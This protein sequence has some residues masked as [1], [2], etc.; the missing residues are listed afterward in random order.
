MEDLT[1]DQ[2]DKANKTEGN[3]STP[4]FEEFTVETSTDAPYE[5]Q[6]LDQQDSA[7]SRI[8]L[9]RK[10]RRR[11]IFLKTKQAFLAVTLLLSLAAIGYVLNG[12]GVI[13]FTGTGKDASAVEVKQSQDEEM[14]ECFATAGNTG[15]SLSL[16]AKAG[17]VIAVGFHEAERKEAYAFNPAGNCFNKET[18]TTV[19]GAVLESGNP[20]MFIMNS[21]GR[22]TAATTAADIAMVPNANVY[23]PVDGVVTLVK[24]Y[25]LYSKITDYHIEIQP[26]GFPDLRVVLIHMDDIQIVE[27]QRVKRRE[28]HIGRMRSLPQINSQILRYLPERADHIHMQI[29]PVVDDAGIES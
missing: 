28:T 5:A 25:E 18:T 6:I 17:S 2:G 13:K 1:K 11:Q 3:S 8:K 16:P 27:G 4:S 24:T 9:K 7:E 20:V 21:R 29:N 15:L 22:G 12:I 26:D 10:L 19:R 14:Y 23:S